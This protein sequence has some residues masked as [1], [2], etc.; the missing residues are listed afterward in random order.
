MRPP[1]ETICRARLCDRLDHGHLRRPHNLTAQLFL[2]DVERSESR[3]QPVA[4]QHGFVQDHTN[5]DFAAV[6]L[7]PIN[8]MPLEAGKIAVNIE[9]RR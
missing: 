2:L 6:E 3:Q 9:F 8:E 4:M 5:A 1:S 7:L